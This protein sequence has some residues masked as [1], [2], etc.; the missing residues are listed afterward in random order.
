MEGRRAETIAALRS[1]REH[2]PDALLLSMPGSDWSAGYL[3]DA[4]TKFGMWDDMLK[5]KAPSPQLTGA[6]VSYLQGR[7]TALAATGKLDEARMELAKAAKL[8][9]AVPAD[10]TQGSNLAR[11]L[12]EIGQLKAEARLASSEGKHEEAAALLGKAVSAEDKLAYNEPRDMLF[13]SRHL[14]GAELLLA[15]KPGEAEAV[16]REDLKRNPDNGWS[17]FGLDKALAAQKRESEAAKAHQQFEAA[18]RRADIQL[19]SSAF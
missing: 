11:P 1:A 8:I 14:L 2:M 13:P 7:A 19:T 18:W 12:Y 4:L 6:T 16:Y 10:A 5:E 15:G 3:Y 9:A 17:W